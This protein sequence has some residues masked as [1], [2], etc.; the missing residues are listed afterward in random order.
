MDAKGSHV[1]HAAGMHAGI[2]NGHE[3]QQAFDSTT[4]YFYY[5]RESTQVRKTFMSE[6][7]Q[8]SLGAL[9]PCSKPCKAFTLSL[10]AP[11]QFQKSHGARTLSQL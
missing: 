11:G 6:L 5:Y 4:G 7:L 2:G 8:L 1:M 10:P 9:K 3:W